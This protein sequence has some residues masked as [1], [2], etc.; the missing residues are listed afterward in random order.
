VELTIT[1]TQEDIDKGEKCAS[2]DCPVALAAARAFGRKVAVGGIG[3][4]NP[5]TVDDMF[6]RLPPWVTQWIGEF[7]FGPREVMTPIE[8]TVTVPDKA[9]V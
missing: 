9:A 6:C 2:I 8:F 1:V 3:I 7:D 4:Y 5:Y